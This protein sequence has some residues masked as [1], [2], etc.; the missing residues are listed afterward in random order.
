MVP[1]I[2]VQN[3]DTSFFNISAATLP[4]KEPATTTVAVG[5]KPGIFF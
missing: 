3:T 1:A 5:A 2:P 4:A